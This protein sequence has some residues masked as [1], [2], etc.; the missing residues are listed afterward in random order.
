MLDIKF[1]EAHRADVEKAIQAKRVQGF[2]LD[3]LLTLNET[4]KATLTRLNDLNTER[5]TR[6]KEVPRIK[7]AGEK[8]KLLAELKN[9]QLDIKKIEEEVAGVEEEF[10][11]MM[12]FCPNVIEDEVPIGKDDSENVVVRQVGE[13]KTFSFKPKSH[14]ELGLAHDLMN[15]ENAVKM[16]GSRSYILKNEGALLELA[17]MRYAVDFVR[18]RGFKLL[19]PPTLVKYEAMEGTAYFPGGEEQAYTVQ[20]DGLYL[21]GTSEVPLM[22]YYM[23]SILKEEELPVL[24]AGLSY[25]YRRE[26][27]TYGK[28]TAGLYRV[29]QFQK[30]EQVVICKADAEESER[31]MQMILKN[32][33]DFTASLELPYR[34]VAV[35][36]GE[37]GQGQRKKYDI[38]AWMPSRG[39]Y[40]ETHSCSK[41]HDFQTRRLKIR[42]KDSRGKTE[43]AH[44]LNNTLVA[45]PRI[46]IPLLEYHQDENGSIRIPEVLQPYMGGMKQIG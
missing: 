3:A 28:D 43:I 26:A 37:M 29:H 13:V 9:L 12:L 2:S 16:A 15:F 20:K 34:V 46:L 36:S 24:F 4:R 1:I 23:D 30:V 17:V 5:N 19:L 44:S 22:S 25:C 14:I 31:M 32:S 38:E 8:Q 45:S 7:D 42:Y 18:T 35:C 10:R 21:I 11:K 40:G 39:G 41:F 27:G 6:S 33:E